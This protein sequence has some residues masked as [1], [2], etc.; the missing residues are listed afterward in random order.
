M[1]LEKLE[2]L[3]EVVVLFKDRYNLV[4]S[5]RDVLKAAVKDLQE[6]VARLRSEREDVRK[7]IEAILGTLAGLGL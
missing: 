7:K 5:E 6:E 3:E 2:K 4:S 1:A